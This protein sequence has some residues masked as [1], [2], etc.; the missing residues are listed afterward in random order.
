VVAWVAFIFW[1]SSD[2]FAAPSTAGWIEPLLRWL[3]PEAPPELLFRLHVA[4]RKGAHAAVYAV[5]ALLVLRALR[6]RHAAPWRRAS[7]VSLA[8]VLLVAA[9]DETHQGLLHSRTGSLADVGLDLLG[10][11]FAL[12][13][14]ALGLALRARAVAG[15]AARADAP[16]GYRH[17]PRGGP[18]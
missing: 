14:A 7:A 11:G 15:R 4:T 8:A 16:L 10:G 17:E 12:G 3:L 9:L 6:R 5:L 1:L 2:L 18:S 13:L